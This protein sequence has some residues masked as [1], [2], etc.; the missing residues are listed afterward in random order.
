MDFSKLGHPALVFAFCLSLYS[1]ATSVYG[2]ARRNRAWIISGRNAAFAVFAFLCIASLSLIHALVRHDF[3][4]QYVA[5]YSSTAMPRQYVIA[6]FWGGMAGSMLLWAWMIGLLTTLVSLVNRRKQEDLMP[7]VIAVLMVNASFFLVLM[8]FG[9]NPFERLPHP[10][11][12]GTQLNPLLQ[13]PSMMIHPPTLYTGY[14]GMVVPFAFAMA[15]LITGR[16]DDEWIRTTRRWTLFAWFFL[17]MGILLGAQWAYVE[18]GWGGYW[19]WDPVENA[20]LMPWLVATAFLH[21]VMIQEKKGMLKVWNVSLVSLAYVLS[22]FGTFLTRSGVL[23]SVHAFSN[24]K[25]G[26]YFLIYIALVAMGVV[27]LI[28][29]RWSHLQSDNEI[30]GFIS[31]ESSF[32]LNNLLLLGAA[33]AIFWGTVYPVISEAIRGVKVTMAAPYFNR[34]MVPIGLTLLVL[35]GFCPLVAWRRASP[36]NLKRN[37]KRPL[38]GAL[39]AGVVMYMFGVRRLL[40]IVPLSCC[41]FVLGTVLLEFYRGTL[42]RRAMTGEPAALSFANLIARNRRRYGGYIV[43]VGVVSLFAGITGSNVYKL[44]KEATLRVGE[45]TNIGDY[46]LRYDKMDEVSNPERDRVIAHLAVWDHG[47][48]VG[49]LLP[50]KNFHPDQDQPVTETAIRG[51]MRDDLYVILVEWSNKSAVGELPSATFKV[52]VNPLVGLVWLSGFF[53]LLGTTIAMLPDPVKAP[54]AARVREPVGLAD[55]AVPVD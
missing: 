30:E 29:R 7:Y 37:F 11:A 38:V 32:L 45:S 9:A 43:H 53:V 8:L 25:L 15:A 49:T 40:G 31:K 19:G 23:S 17:G 28:A 39:L 20:S 13:N 26:S 34:V 14:V 52:F 24:S 27:F 51:T 18:L 36:E 6:A 22:I 55:Q 48:F 47:R 54:A 1:C 12:E 41:A 3:S 5:E 2:A 16:L 46:R 42:A 50:E 33:L 21:S 35:T 44:E 4:Y 10:V